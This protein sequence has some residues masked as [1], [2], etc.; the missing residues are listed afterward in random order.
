MLILEDLSLASPVVPHGGSGWNAEISVCAD[1]AII[2]SGDQVLWAGPR[3]LMADGVT[4]AGRSLGANPPQASARVALGGAL[5]TP[6]LVDCHTHMAFGGD[7]AD[8]WRQRQNGVSYE[9]IARRGGGIAST[10]TATRALAASDLSQKVSARVMAW[11][12]AGCGLIEIKSGYGLNREAEENLLRSVQLAAGAFPGVLRATFLGAHTIP[13]EYQ[14]TRHAYL[15]KVCDEMMPSFARDGLCQAV[16]VFCESIAFSVA[17]AEEVCQA[18]Q[19][20]GLGIHLHAEQLSW[21]G[22]AALAARYSALSADHLEYATDAD[23]EAMAEAGVT[24]VLL[25]GSFLYLRESR[26]PPV[27]AFRRCGVPIAVATDYNPGTSPLRSLTLA[28][29]LATLLFDLTPEESFTGIT[30]AAARA[31]GFGDRLGAIHPGFRAHL[32]VWSAPR[33]ESLFY[34]AGENFCTGILFGES[35]AQRFGPAFE[36]SW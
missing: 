9:E 11:M 4:A 33:W 1:A 28:G 16:D 23:V 22:G 20:L 8:E 14:K 34:E 21:Q 19:R 7:R 12:R 32:A 10:V 5:V 35:E 24:A 6:A 29:S 17:E 27:A 25:P 2:V 26:K 18:A 15:R 31:L 3:S 36:L 30:M 13:I